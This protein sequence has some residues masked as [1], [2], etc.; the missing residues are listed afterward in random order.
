MKLKEIIEN[1]IVF[2]PLVLSIII[3]LCY[4]LAPVLIVIY[5]ITKL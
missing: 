4:L 1:I 2:I 3:G 5:L